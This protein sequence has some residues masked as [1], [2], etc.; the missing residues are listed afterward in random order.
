MS[1]LSRARELIGAVAAR[2]KREGRRRKLE[3]TVRRLQSK[4]STEHAAIGEAVY[5][6]LEA[7]TLTTDIP[8]VT[9]HVKAVSDLLAEIA[10]RRGEIT[11]LTKPGEPQAA[12]M[13]KV[14]ANATSRASSLQV[15]KDVAA[16]ELGVPTEEGGEG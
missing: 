3:M 1:F 7:G 6:L 16:E 12:S 9:S 15:A 5:P 2:G 13:R 14:D 4:V 11:A 10:N 8:Q